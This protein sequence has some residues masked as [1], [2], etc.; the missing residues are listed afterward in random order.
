MTRVCAKFIPKLLSDQQKNL[1]LEIAQD[2]LEMINSDENF[3]KKIIT[4]D[5]TWVYG[6]D[7]ETKQQ[8]S[9]WKFPSEP[10]PK[11]AC[12]SRSNIKSMLV[13]FFIMRGHRFDNKQTV[14]TNAT[15]ALKAISKTDFQECFNKWKH[16]YEQL[17]QSNGDYFE[18][19]HPG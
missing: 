3:L 10:R 5:E 11:K 15:N 14:E 6:Y 2:N 12:Q 18:G 19:C 8:S 4:G 9:Q 13:V 7:P 17:V 16:R 1:R